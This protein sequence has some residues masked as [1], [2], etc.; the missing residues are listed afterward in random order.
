MEILALLILLIL[1]PLAV[2][3]YLFAPWVPIRR[4]DLERVYQIL[5]LKPGEVF[6]ELGSGDGRLIFFLA[7]RVKNPL[8]GIE[9][10][11]WLYFWC[12]VRQKPNTKFVLGDLFGQNL[13]KADVI[14]LFGL[15]RVINNRLRLKLEK[16]AK[17]G[18]RIIS[19]GFMITDWPPPLVDKPDKKH[20]PIFVYQLKKLQKLTT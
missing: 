3:G 9:L 6:Y 12:R 17:P 2:T 11:P 8:V 10:N 1:L 15:P 4:S 18:A 16:E 13:S 5:H 7:N 14:Y 20:L 19:Y